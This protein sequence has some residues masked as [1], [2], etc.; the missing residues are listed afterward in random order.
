VTVI[1]VPLASWKRRLVGHASVREQK[2]TQWKRVNPATL[3]SPLAR[4]VLTSLGESHWSRFPSRLELHPTDW[5]AGVAG[6][7]PRTH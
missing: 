2:G 4:D 5:S 7:G 3:S 6:L 1:V